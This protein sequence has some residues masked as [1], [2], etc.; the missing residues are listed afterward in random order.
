MVLFIDL[1]GDS[2]LGMHWRMLHLD[3]LQ[4]SIFIES[5]DQQNAVFSEEGI[6]ICVLK[7]LKVKLNG[8]S[9]V[10][11]I[12]V[13]VLSLRQDAVDPYLFEFTNS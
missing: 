7:F 10:F 12:V 9:V 4:L 3:N 5:L 2:P 1:I 11:Q 8:V 6:W 13:G